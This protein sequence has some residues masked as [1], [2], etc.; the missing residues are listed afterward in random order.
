MKGFVRVTVK[1]LNRER[2]LYLNPAHIIF[3][4]AEEPGAHTKIRLD[5]DTFFVDE[6]ADTVYLRIAEA[7]K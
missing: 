4:E 1:K 5:I 7:L 3:V 2:T 6:S